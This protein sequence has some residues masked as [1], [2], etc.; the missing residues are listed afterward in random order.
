MAAKYGHTYD[1][2]ESASAAWCRSWGVDYWRKIWFYKEYT[3]NGVTYRTGNVVLRHGKYSR[4]EFLKNGELITEKEFL[5]SI[6]AM[7]VVEEKKAPDPVR[8]A[9]M[10]LEFAF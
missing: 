7:E 8:M 3:Y 9:Q 2:K 4:K 5:Q 10:Q 6:S 1:N